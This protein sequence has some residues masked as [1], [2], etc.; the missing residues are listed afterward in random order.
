[1]ITA[2]T[3]AA[4]HVLNKAPILP[5]FSGASATTISGEDVENSKDSRV[6]ILDLASAMILQ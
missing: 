5:G 6:F 1:M 4:S 3:L 2:S